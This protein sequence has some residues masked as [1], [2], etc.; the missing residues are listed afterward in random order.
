M[1]AELSADSSQHQAFPLDELS[2]VVFKPKHYHLFSQSVSASKRHRHPRRSDGSVSD[3]SNSIFIKQ[4]SG[5][6]T[7]S[8]PSSDLSLDEEREA[9]RRETERQAQAQLEKAKSKPVAFAV[10]TNI[11]YDGTLDD[12][13]AV[14]GCAV[15]FDAREFLHIKEVNIFKS[16]FDVEQNYTDSNRGE[17]SDTTSTLKLGKSNI[18]GHP[19]KE[20][21]K[22]FFKKSE[23]DDRQGSN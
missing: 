2:Q 19:C 7:Y 23:E 22:T 21:K 12:D 17:D 4:G 18:S 1:E 8:Q 6:S 10:R 5:D 20:K 15:S 14:H 16:G 11:A 13:S 9:L 3:S